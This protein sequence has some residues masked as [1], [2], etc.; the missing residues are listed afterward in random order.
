MLRTDHR[1]QESAGFID[2]DALKLGYER[3]NAQERQAM[4]SQGAMPIDA[5]VD[6]MN[7]LVESLHRLT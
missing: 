5:S 6:E 1:V 7:S 2:G 4:I 3:L